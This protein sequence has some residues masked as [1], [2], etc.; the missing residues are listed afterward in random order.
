MKIIG[1]VSEYNP[2]HNGHAYQVQ[3]SKQLLG[4]DGV[5]AIMSGHFV[6]RGYPAFYD[7]W[8]RAEME[9]GRAHV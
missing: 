4:A 9:I 7:K 5:L 8:K 2:F 3:K 1:I 6:Q